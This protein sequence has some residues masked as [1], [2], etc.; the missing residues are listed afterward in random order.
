MEKLFMHRLSLAASVAVFLCFGLTS[1][2]A[3][4]APKT[5][6]LWTLCKASAKKGVS[7]SEKV[8][9]CSAVIDA[10]AKGDA[11][12]AKHLAYA[13]FYRGVAYNH[14][15][16]HD[17]AITDLSEAVKLRPKFSRAWYQRGNAYSDKSMFDLAIGDYDHVIALKP[18]YARAFTNRCRARAMTGK[19]LDKALSDC[20]QALTLKPKDNARAQSARGL[21]YLR[22]GE[23]DKAI[24]DLNLAVAALPKAAGPL[25]LRGVA[26]LKN[27]DK[28]GGNGD[29][30]AAKAADAEITNHYA[31][32]GVVP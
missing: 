10:A 4:T 17:K 9:R 25:Y 26:K 3:A 16:E 2:S 27:G 22:R 18:K 19:E 14:T 11:K 31:T 20:N 29:I 7:D 12:A 23:Y 24:V 13:H 15:N 5:P 1:A 30:A 8:Q 21:I 32:I 28:V 6:S